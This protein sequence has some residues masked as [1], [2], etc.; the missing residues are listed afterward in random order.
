[1][2]VVTSFDLGDGSLSVDGVS[3]LTVTV[4]DGAP[5]VIGLSSPTQYLV[6]GRFY[7]QQVTD[8]LRGS[9]TF[10]PGYPVYGAFMVGSSVT[11]T[12]LGVYVTTGVASSLC[13]AALYDDANFAAGTLLAD[14][15]DLS[16][17]F[18]GIVS[19]SVAGVDL[20]PGVL[21]WAAF[22]LTDG[23]SAFLS[24]NPAG[25]PIIGTTVTRGQQNRAYGSASF[26]PFVSNPSGLTF[27]NLDAGDGS[28]AVVLMGI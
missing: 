12:S 11:V 27:G 3:G 25:M 1:M 2:T 10:N 15:G 4:V 13:R 17:E 26:G 22:Q 20:S 24:L 18:T 28:M 21:Y 9:A 7:D 8:A 23:A 16:S 19:A 14:S 6:T 5:S